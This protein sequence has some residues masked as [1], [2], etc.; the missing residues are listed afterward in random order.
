[1][2]DFPYVY[3]TD[4]FLFFP[5]VQYLIMYIR[6]TFTFLLLCLLKSEP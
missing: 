3:S 5:H 1:M 2:Y 6:F 4:F